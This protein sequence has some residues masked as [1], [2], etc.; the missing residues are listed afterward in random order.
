MDGSGVGV[1]LRLAR[2]VE[3]EAVWLNLQRVPNVQVPL[4]AKARQTPAGAPPRPRLGFPRPRLRG[5][6][7]P[8]E[9][10]GFDLIWSTKKSVTGCGA[11]IE[12]EMRQLTELE[13]TSFEMMGKERER[14]SKC[15]GWESLSADSAFIHA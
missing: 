6:E 10:I 5:E 1:E 2:G 13:L 14:E 3:V 15:C 4:V 7:P 11:R 8:R 9:D 12:L